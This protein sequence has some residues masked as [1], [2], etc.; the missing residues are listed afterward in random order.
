MVSDFDEMKAFVRACLQTNFAT[1]YSDPHKVLKPRPMPNNHKYAY[2]D[3]PKVV[4]TNAYLKSVTKQYRLRLESE[5]ETD[6]DDMTE[7]IL[8]G[9]KSFQRRVFTTFTEQVSLK[10]EAKFGYYLG[11]YK[12]SFSEDFSTSTVGSAPTGWIYVSSGVVT[13][14]SF[15]TKSM[16]MK[17]PATGGSKTS[18]HT[19]TTGTIQTI[20]FD[21]AQNLVGSQ[22]VRFDFWIGN[23]GGYNK[24]Y[25]EYANPT[26][27]INYQIGSTNSSTTFTMWTAEDWHHMNI[28]INKTLKTLVIKVDSSTIL[29]ITYTGTEATMQYIDF[30]TAA[31]G[32]GTSNIYIDNVHIYTDDTII[33]Y[34][35]EASSEVANS[36]QALLMK[37]DKPAMG[38]C[39]ISDVD[40]TM[41]PVG[42]IATYH[43]TEKFRI[44]DL[45]DFPSVGDKDILETATV[46]VDGSTSYAYDFNP[47]YFTNDP[48]VI[49]IDAFDDVGSPDLEFYLP[50]GANTDADKYPYLIITYT[51]VTPT[52]LVSIKVVPS[53][54]DFR[55]FNK[56]NRVLILEVEWF[57]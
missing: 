55:K 35:A 36:S 26:A 9:I 56:Y 51:Y 52:G 30:I 37:F 46:V 31:S 12:N 39:T 7:E 22:N 16:C 33:T 28:V 25:V 5:T 32:G 29:S 19:F 27:T 11:Q 48:L 42:V 43:L 45:A 4:G 13:A 3:Q 2:L 47:T 49:E 18:A 21:F 53:E 38:S 14:A 41:Y 1:I 17:M 54:G 50:D 24:L 40:I 15:G 23:D 10:D 8:A 20:D 34:G 44:M 57:T 6:L